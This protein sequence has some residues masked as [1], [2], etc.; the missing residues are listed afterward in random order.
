MFVTAIGTQEYG[1]WLAT[2]AV[3][4]QL[5][6]VDF[7]LL[8]ALGQ[9][10]AAAYGGSDRRALEQLVG[11]GLVVAFALAALASAVAAGLAPF[12]A[13]AMDIGAEASE[14]LTHCIWIASAAN[15][16][17]LAGF[18]VG[19]LL[20]NLQRPAAPSGAETTAEVAS[21]G[22]T[23]WMVFADFG[24]YA[25][26]IGLAV[27]GALILVG[28][29]YAF[30]RIVLRELELRP[31]LDGPRMRALFE[32]SS[33]VFVTQLAIRVRSYCDPFLVGLLLGPTEA[34]VFALTLR[35]HETVKL[36]AAQFGL[37]ML[38]GLSHLHGERSQRRLWEM[39]AARYKLATAI[40][41][42][43]VGGC[44]VFN[45]AFMSLWVGPGLYAGDAVNVLLAL[46]ALLFMTS[47]SGYDSLFAQGEFRSLS[48]VVGGYALGRL[49]LV[50]L[51]L[52]AWGLLGAAAAGAAT[53][54]LLFAAPVTRQ[55]TRTLAPPPEEFTRLAWQLGRVVL[56]LLALSL[57]A[58]TALPPP[59]DWLAL[60]IQATAFT[61]LGGALVLCLDPA[62][63]RFLLRRGAGTPL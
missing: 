18:G 50:A 61:V 4:V 34:G 36:V 5:T 32:D 53:T 39:I 41:A 63:G 24:L 8:G 25:I 62:F 52:W 28:N 11:S 45:G 37:A 29:L 47:G 26:A 2:G 33:Y 1:A 60:S 38:P 6:N 31:A 27:R 14:R 35:S 30:G 13:Q 21:L 7:G 19:T 42:I 43:G 9:R 54:L 17:Q 3:L 56:G 23:V 58:L 48:R 16:L 10:V 40:A 12:A 22:A 20:R 57:V 49:P 59:R 46:S 44:V 51:G 55:L 15:A